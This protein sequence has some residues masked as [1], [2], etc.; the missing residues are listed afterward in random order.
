MARLEPLSA[1]ERDFAAEH[2]NIVYKFLYVN[3]FSIDDFYDIAVLGY[4]QGVRAYLNREESKANIPFTVM[5]WGY[6]RAAVQQYFNKQDAAKRIPPELILSLDIMD[7]DKV[8]FDNIYEDQYMENV[9][10]EKQALE[11]TVKAFP[12]MQQA[13]IWCKLDGMNNREICK[14]LGILDGKLYREMNKIKAAA[15]QIIKNYRRM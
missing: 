7:E 1:Q 11:T 6:M 4:L 5:A 12:Q 13:I 15:E 14:E 9:A 8:F 10:I 2:H 3:K